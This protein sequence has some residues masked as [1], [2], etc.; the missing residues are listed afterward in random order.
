MAPAYW[1]GCFPQ[2]DKSIESKSRELGRVCRYTEVEG[3]ATGRALNFRLGRHS[4]GTLLVQSDMERR[5]SPLVSISPS[6]QD[7]CSSDLR[8]RVGRRFKNVWLGFMSKMHHRRKSCGALSHTFGARCDGCSVG[9]GSWLWV[10]RSRSLLYAWSYAL[11]HCQHESDAEQ[12]EAG[13]GRL[14]RGDN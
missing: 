14:R 5:R 11:A 7:H 10:M 8:R 12:H 6:G 4:G 2:S 1:H 9:S 13:R 3:A